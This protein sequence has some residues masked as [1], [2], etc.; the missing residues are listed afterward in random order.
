MNPTAK[1]IWITRA[2]PGADATAKRVKAL[3]H[4]AIVAPLLEV[5]PLD[6]SAL[7][8]SDVGGLAFTSANGVR[9]FCALSPARDLKV[10]AVGASTAA[11]AR[12]EGFAQV[13]SAD[14]DV[15]ALAAGIASRHTKSDGAILH[16]GAVEPAGDLVGDLGARGV[17]ARR[18]DLYDTLATRISAEFLEIVS[19]AQVTLLHSPKAATALAKLLRRAPAP[20]LIALGLSKAVLAPLS[21]TKLAYKTFAPFPLEAALLNLIDRIP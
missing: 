20:A 6:S 16:P 18:L 2:Q 5:R 17:R 4:N 7:D 13:L 11:A 15:R 1:T 14:G 9:A 10:F 8:L 12:A 21:R 3:G 19:G